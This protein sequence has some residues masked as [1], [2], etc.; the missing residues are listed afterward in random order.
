MVVV[1]KELGSIGDL[2]RGIVSL[3]I[4]PGVM[5]L[6][7]GKIVKSRADLAARLSDGVWKMSSVHF[8][9]DLDGFGEDSFSGLNPNGIEMG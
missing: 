2:V 1:Q 3:T 5:S 7:A 9:A 8:R 4:A 6:C